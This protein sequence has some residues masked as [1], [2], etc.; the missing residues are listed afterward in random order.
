VSGLDATDWD[1]DALAIALHA[2]LPHLEHARIEIEESDGSRYPAIE[3]RASGGTSLSVALTVDHVVIGLHAPGV[4][5][6][7]RKAKSSTTLGDVIALVRS[8]YEAPAPEVV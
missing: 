7:K 6:F 2:T 8:L 5:E 1:F 4:D 3:M